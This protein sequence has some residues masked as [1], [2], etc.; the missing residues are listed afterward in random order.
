MN[1]IIYGF[2]LVM[3]TISP[4]GDVMGE[5]YDYFTDVNSCIEQG[6]W[7]EE[8]ATYGIG[9]VC[10]EDVETITEEELPN[11]KE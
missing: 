6:I 11:A 7:E 5:V 2:Y 4:Q 1:G 10:L 3:V 9:F 8:N